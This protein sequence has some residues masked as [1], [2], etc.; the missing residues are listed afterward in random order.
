VAAVPGA[1]RLLGANGQ[2]FRATFCSQTTVNRTGRIS[3]APTP[4]RAEPSAAA[5]LQAV[6]RSGPR[7][8]P[9]SPLPLRRSAPSCVPRAAAVLQKQTSGFPSRPRGARTA[10][11]RARAGRGRLREPRA[12]E[13]RG[14]GAAAVPG[15]PFPSPQVRYDGDEEGGLFSPRLSA[16]F[17]RGAAPGRPFPPRGSIAAMERGGAGPPSGVRCRSAAF[18]P[19]GWALG[20]EKGIERVPPRPALPGGRCR[21]S[22]APAGLFVPPSN[23]GRSRRAPRPE[24]GAERCGGR[25]SPRPAGRSARRQPRWWRGGTH[26]CNSPWK[27]GSSTSRY[28][29]PGCG[30]RGELAVPGAAAGRQ[31][32]VPALPAALTGAG[33]P[34][35]RHC[36][37]P[38]S[39][40]GNFSSFLT[41]LFVRPHFSH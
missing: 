19:R 5:A 15:A 10:V 9:G 6:G 2:E 35:H 16:A 33:F 25:A 39:G 36:I 27:D 31:T 37:N 34:I 23:P 29:T 40:I 14:R 17:A 38:H 21:P 41:L 30:R 11:G 1:R 18:R 13:R 28:L 4:L 22:P 20:G 8:V 26:E 7:G 24:A 3:E 12:A 32:E